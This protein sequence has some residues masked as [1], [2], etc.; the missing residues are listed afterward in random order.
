MLTRPESPAPSLDDMT[1][2][3]LVIFTGGTSETQAALAAD[4]ARWD[5]YRTAD[6]TSLY[7]MGARLAGITCAEYAARRQ[8]RAGRVLTAITAL[9]AA[10]WTQA[11]AAAALAACDGNAREILAEP[12]LAAS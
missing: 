4:S 8:A 12:A 9:E 7:S 3:L 2:A 10:G 11:K 6:D 5:R 1:E